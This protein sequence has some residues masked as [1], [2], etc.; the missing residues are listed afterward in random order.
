[1]RIATSERRKVDEVWSDHT[2]WHSVCVFGKAAENVGRY[3]KK[4]REVAV[5]GRIQTRKWT[6]KDGRDRWSTEIIAD[7]IEFL[8]GGGGGRGGDEA[9]EA[10]PAEHQ[11]NQGQSGDIPF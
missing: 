2:E 3:L 9:R 8:G 6:D 5:E 7:Q 1:M 4:G 10:R 11:R